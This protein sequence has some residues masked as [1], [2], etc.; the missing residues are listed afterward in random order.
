[1][2]RQ[3]GRKLARAGLLAGLLALVAGPVLAQDGAGPSPDLARQE[4]MALVYSSNR[5][6]EQTLEGVALLETA[7]QAGDPVAEVSL[8]S[9]YLYGTLLAQD[10]PRALGHFERAAAL[11]DLS[12]IAQYGMMLMWSEQDWQTAQD[13]LE[14]AAQG[15]QPRAWATLAEG[16][17]YG[18][19]G[20]GSLSRAKFAG[21]AAQGRA[22]GVDRIAVLD[23]IRHMWGIS[24]TASGPQTLAI[25]TDA[26]DAGNAEA[27][28]YLVR[29]LRDGNKMNI[30]RDLAAARA[31]LAEYS[32]LFTEP[33]IWQ[34]D[35]T[36]IA[37]EADTPEAR[38]VL[39]N[40]LAQNP[41][42]VTRGFAADLM[43]A[44]ANVAVYMMQRRLQAAGYADVVADGL[45]GRATL[46]A[47][48]QACLGIAVPAA[49]DDTVMQ[50]DVVGALI[51]GLP[52]E[53]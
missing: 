11:G 5:V 40:S 10:W 39:H 9:L 8:G 26:A 38:A 36:L 1:M 18:Y 30:R 53:A 35:M 12:G 44:D 45:A 42:R 25:L 7:A 15:G 50:P 16:A 14:R 34:L 27:A 13:M 47:M 52:P 22:A 41:G 49:C 29:L 46:R 43:K 6:T 3:A 51:A 20:G 23:A 33:E 24:V 2:S 37:V 19:L 48:Y 21:Y 32:A 28:T 17:M 31:A 4:A